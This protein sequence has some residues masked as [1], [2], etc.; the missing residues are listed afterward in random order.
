MISLCF[1]LSSSF[2]FLALSKDNECLINIK[3]ENIRQH[4]ENF[5]VH[6]SRSLKKINHSLKDISEIYFTSQPSG[7]TGLRVSLSFLSTLQVL[8][9]QIKIYHIDTLLFQAGNNNC[10]SL[11]TIDSQGNKYH[12]SI[13]Q[14][15]KNLLKD[16]IVSREELEKIKAKFPSFLILKDFLEVNFLTNFQN[17]EKDF[18]PLEKIKDVNY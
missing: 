11:L 5:L 10:V 17:L 15:K 14:E 8:N 13:Y 2:L 6:L 1:S 12:L 18:L 3:K 4:S 9:S 16:Q 7:Q